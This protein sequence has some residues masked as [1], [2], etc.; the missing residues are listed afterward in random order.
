MAAEAAGLPSL[1]YPQYNIPYPC[2]G[3]G[4]DVVVVGREGRWRL[5]PVN[6]NHQQVQ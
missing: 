4:W 5:K 6:G 3:D 1:R 2:E